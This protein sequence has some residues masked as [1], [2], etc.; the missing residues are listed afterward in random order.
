MFY[1]RP[2]AA[3]YLNRRDSAGATEKRWVRVMSYE[4]EQERY[5]ALQLK[6]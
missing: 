1:F 4:N 3:R 5:P 2:A 6:L